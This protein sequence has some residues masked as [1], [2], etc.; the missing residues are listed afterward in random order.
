MF[1]LSNINAEHPNVL[2]VFANKPRHLHT[3]HSWEFMRLERNG[4]VK[5]HS[6]WETANYGEDIIIANLDTGHIFSLRFL[7]HFS[8]TSSISKLKLRRTFPRD[9]YRCLA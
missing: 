7:Y 1:Y 3:T 8:F 4:Q 5:P 9:V 6:L 2:S